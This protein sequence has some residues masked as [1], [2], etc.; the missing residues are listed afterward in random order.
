MRLISGKCRVRLGGAYSWQF[1]GETRPGSAKKPEP[2]GKTCVSSFGGYYVAAYVL[3]EIGK[4]WFSFEKN[5]KLWQHFV[6]Y[7][8]ALMF[9]LNIVWMLLPDVFF[10]YIFILYTFYIVWEG[11]TIYFSVGDAQRM[12]FT[13]ISTLLIIATPH[14]INKFLLLLMPGLRY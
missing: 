9:T 2:C 11:A 13:T 1:L 10:L 14:I 3:N 8:S 7:S 5:L 6:G 4:S 12:K